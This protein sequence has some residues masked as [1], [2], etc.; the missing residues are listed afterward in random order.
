FADAHKP[1][2]LT[3]QARAANITLLQAAGQVLPDRFLA[4]DWA[5]STDAWRIPPCLTRN[6]QCVALLMDLDRDGTAEILLF[7]VPQ[8]WTAAFKADADGSWALIGPLANAHCQGVLDAL[9]AGPVTAVESRFKEIEVGRERL[10]I[11][12]GACSEDAA[13]V[14]AVK[15]SQDAK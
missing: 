3:V 15:R 5:R 7:S 11:D 2:Q 8:G 9:R 6:A 1:D 4:Q 12:T 13:R 14:R 10:R